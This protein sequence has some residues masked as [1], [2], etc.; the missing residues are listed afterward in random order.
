MAKRA[1]DVMYAVQHT[2]GFSPRRGCAD[3]ITT[4]ARS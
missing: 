3:L 2:D 4:A 1:G